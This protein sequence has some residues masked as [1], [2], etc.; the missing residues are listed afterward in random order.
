MPS[1]ITFFSTKNDLLPI[2]EAAEKKQEIKY[3]R[4]G[5]TKT[6]F[7]DSFTSAAVI[8]RLGRASNESS[9]GSD[10]FLICSRNAEINPRQIGTRYLFDQLLNPETI[11][12][13]PGGLWGEDVLLYGR[14]ASAS[15]ESSSLG[16]LSLFQSI[17]R[18]RFEKIRAFYVGEEA[19][20]MLDHG[21]RLTIA[22]QSARLFDLS[23][24]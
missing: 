11:T 16:L 6:P 23:R 14:F 4:Y 18:K 17:V 20:D 7:P 15:T 9:S 19:A 2:L 13:T 1:Q 24:M 3:V 5:A 21:K 22:A 12:F 10:T 8:P